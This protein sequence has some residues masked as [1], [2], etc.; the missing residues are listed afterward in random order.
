VQAAERLVPRLRAI[1][2]VACVAAVLRYATVPSDLTRRRDIPVVQHRVRSLTE[3]GEEQDVRWLASSMTRRQEDILS[4]SVATEPAYYGRSIRLLLDVP[5]YDSGHADALAADLAAQGKFPTELDTGNVFGFALD[6][7]SDPADAVLERVLE[8]T[9]G[10][11]LQHGP[12]ALPKRHQPLTLLW[13]I[14]RARQG[15]PRRAR[16]RSPR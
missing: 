15:K 14:G 1:V 8:W 4:G 9:R 2:A 7:T 5:G 13:A 11:K 6:L 12:D 3:L 10:L 16:G